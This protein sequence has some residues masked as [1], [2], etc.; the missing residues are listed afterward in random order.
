ME[1]R[2]Q[3]TKKYGCE[4]CALRKKAEANPNSLVGRF[5]RWHTTWCPGW[6]KYQKHL[7]ALGETEH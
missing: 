2:K 3:E 1:T 5:W 6:K 7:K 4:N